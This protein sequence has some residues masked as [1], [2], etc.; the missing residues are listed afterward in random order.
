[1]G[2]P[3]Y[4]FQNTVFSHYHLQNQIVSYNGIS[5]FHWKYI[6]SCCG[7]EIYI[8]KLM[9][10]QTFLKYMFSKYMY[11]ILAC[12]RVY[13]HIFKVL[14]QLLE[15]FS[16]TVWAKFFLSYLVQVYLKG[17]SE[18]RANSLKWFCLFFPVFSIT[19]PSVFLLEF[20]PLIFSH[21]KLTSTSFMARFLT[22]P[23]KIVKQL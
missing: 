20:L 16:G 15:I 4:P 5:L 21:S 18:K 7:T 3:L 2:Q 17:I 10:S 12:F 19:M 6:F 22:E 11:V 1:M 14:N 8:L 23:H 9:F 13:K